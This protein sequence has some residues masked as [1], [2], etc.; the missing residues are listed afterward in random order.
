LPR[1]NQGE[2]RSHQIVARY[3]LLIGNSKAV[4]NPD[5]GA[6][7]GRTASPQKAFGSEMGRFGTSPPVAAPEI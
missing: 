4:S 6:K 2:T 7:V 3:A 5:I 1:D